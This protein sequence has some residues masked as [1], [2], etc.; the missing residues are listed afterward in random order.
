MTERE[1]VQTLLNE[2]MPEWEYHELDRALAIAQNAACR[3][4]VHAVFCDCLALG[5]ELYRLWENGNREPE[6]VLTRWE[7]ALAKVERVSSELSPGDAAEC[8]V[9]LAE[10]GVLA[11]EYE[12]ALLQV[13]KGAPLLMLDS[14]SYLEDGTPTEYYHAL[15]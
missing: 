8:W 1:E 9:W 10:A 12:A 11:N 7:Q 6:H 13:E 14:V 3:G 15:H 5:I 2:L 4:P